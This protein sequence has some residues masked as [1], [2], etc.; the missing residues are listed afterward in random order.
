MKQKILDALDGTDLSRYDDVL[1]KL[2]TGMAACSLSIETSSD[3]HK[4]VYFT[5]Q[6]T[7][8]H[9]GAMQHV[10]FEKLYVGKYSKTKEYKPGFAKQFSSA[11]E[12]M[13]YEKGKLVLKRS[14]QTTATAAAEEPKNK[15]GAHGCEASA[16]KAKKK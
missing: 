7:F 13:L 15:K 3:G 8:E 6:L 1:H 16:T 5:G 9:L 11:V 10:C 12:D 14:T 2:G 4:F